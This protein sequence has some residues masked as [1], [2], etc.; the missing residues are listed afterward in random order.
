MEYKVDFNINEF[1]FWS[2][3]KDTIESIKKNNLMDEL[4]NLIKETFERDIPTDTK[5]NDFVWFE[6]DEI[7][8]RLGLNENGEKEGLSDGTL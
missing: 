7:Y 5:I 3:A 6:R 8:E 4:E 1:K 2:G